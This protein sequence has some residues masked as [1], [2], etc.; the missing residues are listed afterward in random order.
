MNREG[1]GVRSHNGERMRHAEV[2]AIVPVEH[3]LGSYASGRRGRVQKEDQSMK[4]RGAQGGLLRA[5]ARPDYSGIHESYG[6]SSRF[7]MSLT[8]PPFPSRAKHWTHAVSVAFGG[9]P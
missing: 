8:D 5:W 6:W 7:T 4:T 2:V 9:V 1:V 3:H